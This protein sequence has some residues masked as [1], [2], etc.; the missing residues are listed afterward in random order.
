MSEEQKFE[1]E[2]LY[3]KDHEV[4][5][6]VNGK[7]LF[8]KYPPKDSEGEKSNESIDSEILTQMPG[9][10]VKVYVKPGDTVEEG[11]PL[12]VL[13]A[14]KMENEIKATG[15]GKVVEVLVSEGTPVESGTI[16]IRL[17]P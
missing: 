17:E 8:F 3:H 15:S 7:T 13:E 12:V 16:L 6:W 14:M 10:V 4:Y 5:A 11:T 9:R 1:V 2:I